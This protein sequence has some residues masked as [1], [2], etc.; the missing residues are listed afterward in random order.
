MAFGHRD[1]NKN[2]NLR[3]IAPG[4]PLS[5]LKSVL[6]SEYIKPHRLT[7]LVHDTSDLVAHR[8]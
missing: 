1:K 2:V 5:I 8:G 3:L 7:N 6:M 4:S